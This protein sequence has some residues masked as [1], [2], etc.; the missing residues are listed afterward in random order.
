[1]QRRMVET[2]E[3]AHLEALN[4]G[5]RDLGVKTPGSLTG[6]LKGFYDCRSGHGD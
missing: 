6:T 3:S 2:V 5:M 1:M 4:L